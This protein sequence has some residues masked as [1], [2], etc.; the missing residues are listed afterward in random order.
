MSQE[1]WQTGIARLCV[2]LVCIFAAVTMD[3]SNG[4]MFTAPPQNIHVHQC[5][6]NEKHRRVE[7]HWIQMTSLSQLRKWCER[8]EFDDFCVSA[9]L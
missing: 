3:A 1:K 2:R 5:R 6:Q 9:I 8:S 4:H 7:K